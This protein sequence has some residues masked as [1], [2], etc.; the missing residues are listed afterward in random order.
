MSYFSTEWDLHVR[1]PVGNTNSEVAEQVA[2]IL[3]A[4]ETQL[5][6]LFKDNNI[7]IELEYL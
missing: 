7:N 4:C 6:I 3:E 1:M 5:K 2:S